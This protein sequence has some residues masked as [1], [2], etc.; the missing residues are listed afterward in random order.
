MFSCLPLIDICKKKVMKI[1]QNN[2]TEIAGNVTKKLEKDLLEEWL[3]TDETMDEFLMSDPALDLCCSS[4]EDLLPISPQVFVH[5]M[6]HPNEIP[7]FVFEKTHVVFHYYIK[8]NYQ[9][10]NKIRL[11]SDCFPRESKYYDPCS[12]NYWFRDNI[13]YKKC[14]SHNVING[15]EIL[16]KIIWDQ[17]SWCDRCTI[18]PLFN[19]LD[20]N[21]CCTEY[22]FHHS[23]KRPWDS[24]SDDSCDNFNCSHSQSIVKGNRRSDEYFKT[25]VRFN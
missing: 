19:L 24:D 10:T 5:L 20:D 2:W 21:D 23:R 15:D 11:C 1:Y 12:A 6:C 18:T 14:I 16:E 13:I 22:N 3:R 25:H 4:W 17:Y 9:D 7:S 8:T